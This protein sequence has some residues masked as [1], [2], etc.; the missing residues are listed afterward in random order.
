MRPAN[1][2]VTSSLI[3]WAHPQHDPCIM[4]ASELYHYNNHADISDMMD[5]QG[6]YDSNPFI[7]IWG[8]FTNIV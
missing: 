4:V 8:P 2:V 3:G 1:D 7:K 5:N 6:L